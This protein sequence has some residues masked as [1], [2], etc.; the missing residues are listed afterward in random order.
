M[1]LIQKRKTTRNE[2]V[3]M[4]KRILSFLVL[5]VMAERMHFWFWASVA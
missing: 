5:A 2:K 3:K 1:R 4:E